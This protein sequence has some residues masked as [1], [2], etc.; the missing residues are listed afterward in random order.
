MTIMHLLEDNA[1]KY[2]HDVA[3]VEINPDQPETRKLTWHEFELVQSTN[4]R[5]YRREISWAVFT[6]LYEIML[7]LQFPLL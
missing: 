3:L 5:H 7:A 4:K 1:R 2:P 6:V